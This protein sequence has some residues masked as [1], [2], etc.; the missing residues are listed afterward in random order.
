MLHELAYSATFE[1]VRD[2]IAHRRYA[3]DFRFRLARE[4]RSAR[5]KAERW[6]RARGEADGEAQ[7]SLAAL[8]RIYPRL[9]HRPRGYVVAS[10][11]R[12][13]RQ[14]RWKVVRR[15]EVVLLGLRRAMVAVRR[16]CF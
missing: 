10:L 4:V 6:A 13:L 7:A 5:R 9:A 3:M 2:E 1:P 16:H 14:A 12:L 11:T 15:V 8:L